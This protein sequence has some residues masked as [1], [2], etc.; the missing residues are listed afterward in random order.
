MRSLSFRVAGRLVVGALACIAAM[1][2]AWAADV[3]AVHASAPTTN[4]PATR[5]DKLLIA[6]LLHPS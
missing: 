2:G 3:P 5:K 6:S 1:A 4:R